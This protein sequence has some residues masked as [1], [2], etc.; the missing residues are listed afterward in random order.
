M[1]LADLLISDMT[2]AGEGKPHG[3]PDYYGWSIKPRIY[4]GN[5]PGD[6]QAMI[7]WGQVYEEAG[8]NPATNSRVQLQNIQTFILSKSTGQWVKIQDSQ[9]VDGAAFRENYVG[10]VNRPANGIKLPD[11]S[12]AVTAGQGFNY[13]FWPASG[14]IEIDPNDIAGI[15]TSV[16]A[17]LVV[18]DPSQPDDRNSA[19]YVLNMGGDYWRNTSVP[20]NGLDVNNSEIG[21]G[22]F[23]Y[24]TSEWQTF[25]MS[26]LNAN[27]LLNN[28]PPINFTP[29]VTAI[30]SLIG[31]LGKDTLV[32]T[33]SADY[34][35][36][37][38]E[39][40]LLLA[41]DEADVL[42]GEQ[43]DDA[44]GGEVGSDRLFGGDGNDY[45]LGGLGDD[46]LLGE[47]ENDVLLGDSAVNTVLGGKDSLDGGMGSD[48]LFSE[49]GDDALV[50]G[51]GHDYLIA[52]DG[53][54]ALQGDNGND[55]LAGEAGLDTLAGGAESDLLVGG[56]GDDVFVFGAPGTPFEHIGIDT[57]FDF[58]AGDK[59][60]LSQATFTA[61]SSILGDGFSVTSEFASVTSNGDTSNAWIVY[62][63]STGYLFYNPNGNA[64]GFGTGGQF[65]VI[66]GNP[67]LLA[68][69][70]KIER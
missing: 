49:S 13:H 25:S 2:L 59:L 23:K 4:K 45:L 11:G 53:L 43:G 68:S 29:T 38:G 54:D 15:V 39:D 67:V 46:I 21:Q 24:V 5:D 12:I 8:G 56:S 51:E 48:T 3:V 57:V 63:S 27:L 34:L 7:A 31:G 47:A 36:G 58:A 62:D 37:S 66:T 16:E 19:N 17:R 64:A 6:F 44:L 52:G 69:D 28:P 1:N 20:W 50:G 22:R 30:D 33:S 32:G 9:A 41:G 14:K 42:F 61:L 18:A 10:N 40:D 65:A 35:R 60:A 70:F 26:T 55:V